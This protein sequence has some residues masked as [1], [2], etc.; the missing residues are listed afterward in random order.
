MSKVFVRF[1]IICF[2]ATGFCRG[3]EILIIDAV[4]S[5]SGDFC[6]D[7]IVQ[8]DDFSA[9]RVD[10]SLLG[11][12][13]KRKWDVVVLV[14]P[15]PAD[16]SPEIIE[17]LR[18]LVDE[19]KAGLVV[20][21]LSSIDGGNSAIFDLLGKRS[22]A[23]QGTHYERYFENC[24]WIWSS[25]EQKASSTAYFRT[26]FDLTA[27]PVRAGVLISVDDKRKVWINGEAVGRG[28]SWEQSEFINI[29][30][31]LVVGKNVF[32]VEAF[33][34]G[35]AAGVIASILAYDK[36][37]REQIAIHSD[38]N[39]KCSEQRDPNWLS[40]S[41]NDSAWH[42]AVG[43]AKI[44]FGPWARRV[45][46]DDNG[47]EQ[48]I[49]TGTAAN[50]IT[51]GLESK[52]G[53]TVITDGLEVDAGAWVLARAG[54]VPAAVACQEGGARTVILGINPE[55]GR[56]GDEDILVRA[57]FAKMVYKT[58]YW[59]AGRDD[60]IE[61]ADLK[62]WPIQTKAAGEH[63]VKS[64]E[65]F[66]I[67]I[68]CT[69][70]PWPGVSRPQEYP[71][72]Q[73][74]L[75]RIIDS[76]AEHGFSL[77]VVPATV[78]DGQE[79]YIEEYA[80]KQG[81]R[82]TFHSSG[83]ELFGRDAPPK[84]CV[85]SN[86]YPKA[87]RRQVVEQLKPMESME[88]VYNALVYQD[89]PFHMGTK[90]F[91]Y[92]EEVRAEF[93]KRYGYELPADVESIR[94]DPCKWL[95]VIN[96]RSD[97]FPDGWRQVYKI[98]KESHP[99]IDILM[100]HDSHNTFGGG[101]GQESDLAID[102]VY[103][104]GA[105]FADTLIF[106][107]YPYMMYDFRYGEHK[108]VP[109]PRLCQT[110]FAM[111]QMR[112]VTTA[113]VKKWGFWFGTYNREWFELTKE[114]RERYWSERE[115][116]FTAVAAGANYLI[117][118]YG[119]PEDHHHWQE[120]GAGTRLL[121]KAG[122]KV[123]EAARIKARAAMLF[124]RTQYIQLQKEY[125]NVGQSFECFARA[126][127]ELDM[128]H[129]E[130]INDSELNGYDVLLLFDVKLLP[131]DKAEHIISFLKNGGVVIADSVPVLGKYMEPMDLMEKVFGAK[132]AGMAQDAG[133][134]KVNGRALGEDFEMSLAGQWD[135]N[136]SDA[137]VLLKSADE[138]PVLA[139]K[140][141]GKG[142]AY[143]LGFS[144][145]M[146][147]FATWKNEDGK[148]RGALY[149]LLK[150]ITNDSGVYAHVHSSNPDIEAAV[151][152][153]GKEGFVFVI[154]HEPQEDK[155]MVTIRDLPFAIDKITN[156]END[157]Q[158]KFNE[159]EGAVQFEIDAPNGTTHLLYISPKVVK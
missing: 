73:R 152:A 35:G 12:A 112:D 5:E 79:K 41:F 90:S 54:M 149:R 145:Q 136:I 6:S 83:A 58:L 101:V 4:H 66:P 89:E 117:A 141:V 72:D 7:I 78:S 42:E 2:V 107:I 91:G 116:C 51:N 148:S 59:A 22:P 56:P 46:R 159:V 69:P 61:S 86:E 55:L 15:D 133:S 34:V 130:Q 155:T 82:M 134:C 31:H 100:T 26:S 24:S 110:H 126:F 16:Y 62:K 20:F 49:E 140:S 28:G 139:K 138:K 13:A 105:D 40:V 71:R 106:D 76:I 48:V 47:L 85:Y 21:G 142:N 157:T 10:L 67:A 111:A 104:W 125:W 36:A 32:C 50:I 45:R 124:P 147:D 108:E 37:G 53:T 38:T 99:N 75:R 43:L 150:T 143:L 93:K 63:A 14:K 88:R 27:L 33:N 18:A 158:V 127:G 146:A 44:G 65:M 132:Q 137:A 154:A 52:L 70:L 25:G 102:D 74:G 96:F 121:Q 103:H 9:K 144:L 118:G 92:G 122:A 68:Q 84:V 120:L 11:D 114:K 39:W 129:E 115:M 30:E 77:V 57:E 98:I 23:K 81:L 151:R 64:E 97:Y 19:K 87:V 123:L 8:S 1:A 95:D 80:A 135:L 153:N 109:K 119:I 3:T 29:T 94:K 17:Q 156:L 131:R 128:I 113:Y 60:R